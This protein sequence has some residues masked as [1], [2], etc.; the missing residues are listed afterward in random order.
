MN[1]KPNNTFTIPKGYK[2]IRNDIE[3][4]M[5]SDLAVITGLNGS[6]K[7]TLLKHIFE[8]NAQKESIFFKTQ[9]E[10]KSKKES[11][12]YARRLTNNAEIPTFDSVMESI[13]AEFMRYNRSVKYTHRYD[14]FAMLFDTGSTLYDK[15]Y[16]FLEILCE[17]FAEL[18]DEDLIRRRLGVPTSDQIKS[19]T[20]NK[21][22]YLIKHGVKTFTYRTGKSEYE[23]YEK[24]VLNENELDKIFNI[25][26]NVIKELRESLRQNC[27]I[28]SRETFESYINELV[29]NFSFSI[30]SIVE[31]MSKRIYED[32]KVKSAKTK[33][34]KL[35][36]E[37]NKEL[38]DY[39]KDNFKYKINAPSIYSSNYEINFESTDDNNKN[40]HFDSLSSGEKVVFELICYYF[41][42][43]NNAKLEIII[44]DE[45]DANL[46]PALA[47]MYLKVIRK[48]FCDRGIA[49]ILTTHAP[50]T[51]VEV[52]PKELFE[53]SINNNVQEIICANDEE[54]KR[55]ILQKLAPNFIYYSEFGYLE[56]LL[57]PKTTTIVLL[58]GKYDKANLEDLG[59]LYTFINCAGTGNIKNLLICLKTIPFFKRCIEDKLII[60]LFDFDCKG[61]ES[62]TD[63]L[64]T[65]KNDEFAKKISDKEPLF[66]HHEN[67]VYIATFVPPY[68]QE[69]WSYDDNRYRHQELKKEGQLGVSRQKALLEKI[70]EDYDSLRSK[71]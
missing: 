36:Q 51:V 60:A 47:A 40:V 22:N 62:V 37:I 19:K 32:A 23:R 11:Y 2:G 70:I 57:K 4:N 9:S 12:Y 39:N 49:T 41:I 64:N 21:I 20:I 53:L 35:W 71:K 24:K 50:S 27:R 42:A 54:G 33:T 68:E 29:M 30:E 46:N 7:T 34:L 59:D 5:E 6:G 56:Y 18:D 66:L 10:E 61:R 3:F 26:K 17:E 52:E 55:K 48:Q 16:K 28:N 13:Y 25:E 43:H 67:N 15:G 38:A 69:K 58:E 8:N 45:F 14:L 31:K 1:K 44:L 65:S 63:I